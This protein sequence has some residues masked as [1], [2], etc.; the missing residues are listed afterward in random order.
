MNDSVKPLCINYQQTASQQDPS[1]KGEHWHG[2]INKIPPKH[3]NEWNETVPA[4]IASTLVSGVG[5]FVN[6]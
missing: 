5:G 4:G 2:Q 3:A 6:I 1:G